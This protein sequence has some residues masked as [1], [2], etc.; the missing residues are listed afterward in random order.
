MNPP[1]DIG[2]I[3]LNPSNPRTISTESKDRLRRSLDQFGDISGVVFNRKTG[4]LV[5]A[6]QRVSLFRDAG[7]QLHIEHRGDAD[8]RGTVARGYVLL[9]GDRYGYREVEWDL[10]KEQA[11]MLAA[12]NHAGEWDNEAVSKIIA[13]LD[14]DLRGLTG[15]DASEIEKIIRGLDRSVETKEEIYKEKFMIVIDCDSESQQISLLER[16]QKEGTKCKALTS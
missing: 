6:N 10:P 12:N 9:D 8:K 2:S 16:F 14:D 3:A 5:G 4:H 1:T 13:E 15:F 7:A 11:A